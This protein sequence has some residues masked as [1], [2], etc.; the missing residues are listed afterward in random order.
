[1]TIVAQQINGV[2]SS[3]C[4]DTLAS[5]LV[6]AVI[7]AYNAEATIKL[8]IDS[9]LCQTI[10]SLELLICDDAST[11]ATTTVVA[12]IADP[13][14]RLLQN[15]TNLGSGATRDRLIAEAKGRWIA[16]CDA[17]DM[18]HPERLALLVE[19]AGGND[20]AI[21]FDDIMECHSAKHGM[22]PWRSLRGPRAFGAH[23]MPVHVPAEQLINSKRMFI[24]PLFSR[25]LLL[26]SKA[27][28][29]RHAYGED[30]FF[31]LKLLAADGH[32]IYVPAARYLYRITPGSASNNVRHHSLLRD[33]LENAMADFDGQPQIQVAL[34]RK[35][36]RI[37]RQEFYHPFVMAIKRRSAGEAMHLFVRR[38][39]LL[40]EFIIRSLY[41]LP[42]H[43]HRL[44]HGGFTRGSK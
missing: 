17:D 11:D 19:A 10:A 7:P 35:I 39:W 29:S 43:L 12:A 4:A 34:Q 28:H 40:S 38:P 37:R 5:P 9:I 6:T 36:E 16:F 14:V 30:S 31:L 22:V 32:L 1:M 33:A 24:K 20:R 26:S 41:D 18:W 2:T 27:C 13:R 21:V 8:A 23:G 3:G 44:R 42:Y 25:A 15:N